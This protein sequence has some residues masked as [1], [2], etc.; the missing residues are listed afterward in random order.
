MESF[1]GSDPM[2]HQWLEHRFGKPPTLFLSEA[3]VVEA[4]KVV[5]PGLG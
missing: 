2:L 1:L 4:L 5:H 3:L